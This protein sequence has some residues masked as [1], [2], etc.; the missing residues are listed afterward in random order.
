[1]YIVNSKKGLASQ[2]LFAI[3]GA[4]DKH[5]YLTENMFMLLFYNVCKSTLSVLE[6]LLFITK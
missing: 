6:S 2:S 3:M 5:R 4:N 1:M